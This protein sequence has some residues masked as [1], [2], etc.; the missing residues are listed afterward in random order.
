[1][2]ARRALQK[3]AGQKRAGMIC[4]AMSMAAAQPSE[5]VEYGFSEYFLGLTIP[6]SGYL[7]PPGVYFANTFLLYQGSKPD[8]AANL[9]T[10]IAQAGYLFDTDALGGTFG[11]YATIP[12]TGDKNSVPVSTYRKYADIS[13]IGDTDYS[14]VLGWHAGDN[15]WCIVLTG[16]AP[17]G[18]YDPQR[19]VQTGLNRPALD[20]KGAYTFLNHQ[21]GAEVTGA[22]GMTFNAPNNLTNY[23][24]GVEMHFEW[25]LNQHFPMGV[26]AGLGG[27]F[28]QQLTSDSGSGDKVGSNKGRAVAVG[29]LLSYALKVGTQEVDLSGRWFHEFAV[30]NRP[31]GDLIYATMSFRL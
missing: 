27:F 6:M 14:A 9:V 22:L 10:D 4:L 3:R 2:E 7:P 31:Q 26:S 13:S 16:F 5:A 29:P 19:I 24:S 11:F 21:T 20:M 30:E 23:Q 15:H 25:A 28:Y 8:L 1:M 18:N 17:T 12:F